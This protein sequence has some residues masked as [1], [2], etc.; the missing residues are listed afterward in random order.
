LLSK[1]KGE[2][3]LM[4]A[5]LMDAI[6]CFQ[7]YLFSSRPGGRHLFKEAEQWI[8]Q[9]DPSYVF[10]FFRI[11]EA[12][13]L[14]PDYL[15]EGLRQWQNTQAARRTQY[16]ALPSR[17]QKT[18]ESFP[19]SEA[20][21]ESKRIG[22]PV[23]EDLSHFCCQ[24]PE[25]AGFGQKGQGNLYQQG[26]TN[27]G[28]TIRRLYCRLC[29]RKFSERKGM[30][31]FRAVLAPETVCA[32]VQHLAKGDS[33]RKTARHVGISRASVQRLSRRLREQGKVVYDER[34]QYLLLTVLGGATIL[35]P[36]ESGRRQ[37]EAGNLRLREPSA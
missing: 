16:P 21:G 23:G 6:H 35:A 13:G 8:K 29:G 28:K 34:T 15:R 27:K 4:A 24:N 36:A 10:S 30:V 7:T 1:F 26:W 32:A 11:C 19:A 5:V 18:G 2:R 37:F 31:G 20:R 9:T 17:A 12:L 14:D 22:R 25:C 33:I 3:R